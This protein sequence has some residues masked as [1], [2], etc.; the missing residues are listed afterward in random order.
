[1]TDKISRRDLLKTTV[2]AGAS[3]VV[4]RKLDGGLAS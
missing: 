3:S 2:A 1:M 4:L